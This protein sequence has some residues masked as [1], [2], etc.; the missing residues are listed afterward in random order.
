MTAN[1]FSTATTEQKGEAANALSDVLFDGKNDDGIAEWLHE[2]L[3]LRLPGAEKILASDIDST[4]DEVRDEE[5]PRL[6]IE[7]FTT[8]IF[9]GGSKQQPGG[10]HLRDKILEILFEKGKYGKILNIWNGT[11]ADKNTR[12]EKHRA[13]VKDKKMLQRR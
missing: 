9:A 11:P 5:L 13:Y 1:K 12:E 7:M 3:E 4:A 2:H 6:L 8:E 10:Y